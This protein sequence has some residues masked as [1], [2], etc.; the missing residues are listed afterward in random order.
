MYTESKSLQAEDAGA[1]SACE[2]KTWLQELAEKKPEEQLKPLKEYLKK[3]KWTE[4]K[5]VI[6]H[7]KL[8]AQTAF[9][10]E[11]L[12]FKV[13]TNER[14]MEFFIYHEDVKVCRAFASNTNIDRAA[15]MKIIKECDDIESK[16]LAMALVMKE[17]WTGSAT[18]K[19]EELLNV[20]TEDQIIEMLMTNTQIIESWLQYM[21][22]DY[23]ETLLLEAIQVHPNSTEKIK[24][25]V[26]E[27]IGGHVPH[28]HYDWFVFQKTVRPLGFR[29][30][31]FWQNVMLNVERV[32]E[33]D[34]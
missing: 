4:V 31:F 12:T 19:R 21:A 29:W 6:D 5:E 13:S 9:C 30:S 22:K 3:A 20:F 14:A 25:I 33:T 10:A 23:D 18:S 28:D 15:R 7:L 32:F 1:Q 24:K 8:P 27:K 2:P 34:G 11:Y 16:I 26:A 17:D